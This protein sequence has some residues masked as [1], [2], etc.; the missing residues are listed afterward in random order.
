[1]K[2][3]I[4]NIL[5]KNQ[6]D[7]IERIKSSLENKK[8][9][10]KEEAG[11]LIMAFGAEINYLS[12]M[13]ENSLECN[14]EAEDLKKE[15]VEEQPTNKFINLQIEIIDN[16]TQHINTEKG[17]VDNLKINYKMVKENPTIELFKLLKEKVDLVTEFQ[18]Q[19]MEYFYEAG[20]VVAAFG[21]RER[22]DM[23]A[24]CLKRLDRVSKIS[25]KIKSY[26]L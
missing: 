4:M 1:M 8:K 14:K 19:R 20:E 15:L 2:P 12:K 26:E 18:E 3:G 13:V 25:E 16:R 5:T 7:K 23:Q 11:I 10:S 9:L 24:S 22:D 21:I 6:R 17:Y